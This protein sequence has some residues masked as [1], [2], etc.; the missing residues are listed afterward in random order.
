MGNL[1]RYFIVGGT[2]LILMGLGLLVAAR[3]HLPLGHLPGDIRIERH[4]GVFYFPIA[5]SILVSVILTAVL[6][7]LLRFFRR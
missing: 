7:V 2:I 4:G 5:T 1:A 3:L 6:N